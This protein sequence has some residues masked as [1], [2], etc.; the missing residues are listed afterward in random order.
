MVWAIEEIVDICFSGPKLLFHPTM[1]SVDIVFRE[2]TTSN[3]RLVCN[4]QN[5]ESMFSSGFAE[6]KNAGAEYDL[7][8]KVGV[9]G[10]FVDNAVP[11]KQ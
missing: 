9:I 8:G 3:S 4:Y 1:K 6:V 7:F 10:I 5:Q 2:I 11:V